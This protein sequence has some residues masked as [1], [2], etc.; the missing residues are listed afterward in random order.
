MCVDL[1]LNFLENRL[2]PSRE[3][4][5]YVRLFMKREVERAESDFF[6]SFTTF[7]TESFIEKVRKKVFQHRHMASLFCGKAGHTHGLPFG[8]TSDRTE[9]TVPRQID[10]CNSVIN[11]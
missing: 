4:C 9:G 5:S 7:S 2:M 10:L 8:L 1:V 6:G 3:M 11:D